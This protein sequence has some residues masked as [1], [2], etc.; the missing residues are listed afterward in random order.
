M[1][2]FEDIKSLARQLIR[3]V[4]NGYSEIQV[5]IIPE[6]KLPKISKIDEKLNR[7][8]SLDLTT[9][10]RQYRRRKNKA[11]FVGL[12]YKRTIIILK[13]KGDTEIEERFKSVLGSIIDFG[14]LK[15]VLYKDEREKLTF[16]IER[17]IYRDMK[18]KILLSIKNRQGRAFHSEISKLYTLSKVLPYRGV[19]LQISSILK[20]IQEKQK[21]HGTRWSVPKFFY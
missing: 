11:N 18:E 15:I 8:Y 13:S 1:L 14:Y 2:V 17:E 19:N 5:S 3:Y 10:Q 6:K 4:G 20:T 12:R 7:R 9:Y 16:K 21:E